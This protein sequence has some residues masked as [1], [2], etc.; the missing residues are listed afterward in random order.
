MNE[1]DW[2]VIIPPSKKNKTTQAKREVPETEVTAAIE[3]FVKKT[4]SETRLLEIAEKGCNSKMIKSNTGKFLNQ[5]HET[6]ALL[7]NDNTDLEQCL[8]EVELTVRS[9]AVDKRLI[10][11]ARQWFHAH[12]K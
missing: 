2:E 7:I 12:S 3:K 9:K 4:L 1:G 5:M 6:V 11:V 8:K 10:D